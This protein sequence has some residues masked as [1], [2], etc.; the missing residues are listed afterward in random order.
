MGT[1]KYC[2]GTGK[3]NMLDPVSGKWVQRI[4]C[5]CQAKLEITKPNE[6]ADLIK[7]GY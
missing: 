2:D 3:V 6:T 5:Q 4:V 7:M 1:C